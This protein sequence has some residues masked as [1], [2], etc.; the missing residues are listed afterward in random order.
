MSDPLPLSLIVHTRNSAR[1]LPKLLDT[2]AWIAERVVVDMQSAD[3]TV[4]LAA[5]ARCRV[6]SIEPSASVDAIRNAYLPLAQH[7]W[8]LVLDSDEYLSA[9]AG[10]EIARLVT[11]APPGID[12]FAIPR[13]NSIAGHIMRGSAWYPDQQTRLFRSDTVAWQA[14]HHRLPQVVGGADH[15][16]VLEPPDCLHIHH[17]NYASLAEFIERQVH[18][19]V[20]DAYPAEFD[21]NRYLAA[22]Y[23]EFDRRFDAEADG[24]ISTALAVLMSWDQIVRGVLHWEQ[25]GRTGEL[26]AAFT[27]PVVA[28]IS[29][30]GEI[31]RLRDR[32]EKLEESASFRVTAPLRWL[33]NRIRGIN[34]GR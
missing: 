24:G 12:A 4:E 23:E 6:I 29:R 27:L 1:T 31:A 13:F 28:Q 21:F 16:L 10:T 25:T 9:D 8:I 5:A 7:P 17:D 22:A 33:A 34:L 15:L 11:T 26:G 3:G 2:T 19:A 14:G 32:I 18:Y 20:T 30:T